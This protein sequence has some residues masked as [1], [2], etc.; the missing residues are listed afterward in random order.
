MSWIDS[1]Y[2]RLCLICSRTKDLIDLGRGDKLP[3][4]LISLASIIKNCK[5]RS[6][7]F[8][9]SFNVIKML[10]GSND[11]YSD[12][13]IKLN[14]ITRKFLYI[15]E[16]YLEKKSWD[17]REALRF[18]AAANIVDANVLGY[19]AKNLDEAIWDNPVIEE[20]LTIPT[21][22]NI[23]IILD[24]S[25][26]VI[27]DM[28]LVKALKK[29]GYNVFIVIR[30]ESYEIDVTKSDLSLFMDINDVEIIETP[31]NLSPVFY[32]DNGFIIAK[33]I[34]NAEAYIEAGRVPSMHLFRA[35]CDVIAQKFG[36]PKN[37]V[38]IVSGD[39]VKKYLGHSYR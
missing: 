31:G 16:S 2:C 22:S 23:Y 39:T 27:V 14:N 4:L 10:V 19:Q 32:I 26:E 25:G 30:E 3:E 37:S 11:P 6:K 9:E 29:C 38:L 34:A 21:G 8:A 24:N 18:S 12:V 17:V 36:I 28:L 33:G 1:G 5:S 35:K 15:I 7:A 20:G 13:K